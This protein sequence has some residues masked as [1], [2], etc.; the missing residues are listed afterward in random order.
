MP[1]NPRFFGE[2]KHRKGHAQPIV[3]E[4]VLRVAAYLRVST[5]EQARSG[6]G[7]EAQRAQ[8]RAMAT[9]K[10]W[11]APVEYVEQGVS[12]TKALHSRDQMKLLMVAIEAGEIDALIVPALDR[13]G[14]TTR[15][16]L[17]GVDYLAEHGVTF[18]SCRESFDTSTPTGQFVVTIFAALS[19]MERDFIV[20]RTKA[21]LAVKQTR[22]G[23]VGGKLPYGYLRVPD[24]GIII[25]PTEA[26]HARRIIRLRRQK[27]TM[28]AI[29]AAMNA[30]GIPSP[31]GG[32][33]WA[34]SVR[35]VLRNEAAYRGG[36]RGGSE[37]RWPRILK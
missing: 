23:E 37:V 4:Q 11:P 29:A 32:M 26:E 7:L 33:W 20:G 34:S 21:A 17:E 6:L 9:V 2:P 10:H 12:G 35:E 31:K 1:R 5:D 28:R 22:D 14:R 36:K 27:L 16:I 15:I 24:A 8:V 18:V 3:R 19:Q 13:L 30:D 25:D